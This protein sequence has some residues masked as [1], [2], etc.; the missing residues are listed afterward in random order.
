[1]IIVRL[2]INFKIT[3]Q[4]IFNYYSAEI[5]FCLGGLLA[6]KNYL[7]NYLLMLENLLRLWKFN[8]VG[9]YTLL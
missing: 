2:N 4:K 6:Q 1:M 7:R 3:K 8:F 9:S 5:S